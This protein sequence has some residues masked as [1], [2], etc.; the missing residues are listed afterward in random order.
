MFW[1]KADFLCNEGARLLHT[2]TLYIQLRGSD[3]KAIEIKKAFEGEGGT[4][5]VL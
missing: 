3:R 4:T 1:Q 5:G 2:N